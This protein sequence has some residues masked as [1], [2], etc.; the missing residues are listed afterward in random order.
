MHEVLWAL[1]LNERPALQWL[2]KGLISLPVK[3]FTRLLVEFENAVADGGPAHGCQ[4]LFKYFFNDLQVNGVE[5]IPQEGPVIL[6]GNHPG[7]M[8]FVAEGGL[9]GRKDLMT[10]SSD[11]NFMRPLPV[12]SSH[13]AMITA[14]PR[15]RFQAL[16][17][18]IT[19]LQNGGILLLY[20]SGSIDPDPQFFRNAK[21]HLS[22]WSRSLEVYL[23]KVPEV[24]IVP[25]ISSN[26][27]NERFLFN[28]LVMTQKLRVE[29]QRAA[30][31]LQTLNMMFFKGKRLNLQIS[32]GDPLQFTGLDLGDD[33]GLRQAKAQ[34]QAAAE[35][36][37]DQHM[38][39]FPASRSELWLEKEAVFQH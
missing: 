3:K 5:K 32:F 10:I 12:V 8:D 15:T 19:H 17:E 37:Y 29:R 4:V 27:L 2:L 25:L 21:D 23:K 6:A 36:L 28:K 31:F 39:R 9:A 11:V 33:E 26:V 1:K 34:L 13:M 7:G 20:P 35:A 14:D 16:K 18:T 38:L 22:R 30:E 24:Q